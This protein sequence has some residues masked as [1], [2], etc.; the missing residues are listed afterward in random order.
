MPRLISISRSPDNPLPSFA[1]F[2]PDVMHLHYARGTTNGLWGL[3]TSECDVECSEMQNYLIC[4]IWRRKP[5]DAGS[6][7][8]D[9]FSF[10][11]YDLC[12]SFKNNNPKVKYIILFI[13]FHFPFPFAWP[14]VRVRVYIYLFDMKGY[15]PI[16][17]T[18]HKQFHLAGSWWGNMECNINKHGASSHMQ[19][20]VFD[21]P[22][23]QHNPLMVWI[24]CGDV[25]TC[26]ILCN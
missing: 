12:N 20:N 18:L 17:E 2:P 9:C 22:I 4:F 6:E 1:L 25:I 26:T 7:E 3:A 13:Y 5:S 24:V 11:F 15:L 23:A 8:N 16:M 14:S 10:R 19:N 21:T